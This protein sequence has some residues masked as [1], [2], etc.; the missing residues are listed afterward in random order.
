MDEGDGESLTD[1]L[2]C[3]QDLPHFCDAVH[4]PGQAKVHDADVSQRSGRSQQDVLGLSSETESRLDTGM[5]HNN[6]LRAPGYY[7]SL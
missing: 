5:L 4:A 2:R 6:G 3:A 1:I 7:A